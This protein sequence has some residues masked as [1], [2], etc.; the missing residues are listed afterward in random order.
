MPALIISHDSALAF[1][2]RR[3]A[4][5]PPRL[6]SANSAHRA[7]ASTR[8]SMNS[9]LMS[10]VQLLPLFQH[11]PPQ[12]DALVADPLDHRI[13][14]VL[15]LHLQAAPLPNGALV[16]TGVSV[17]Y[18]DGTIQVLVC[19]PE[20]VFVQMAR[21][22]CL[23]E[24]IELGFEL[25]GQFAICPDAPKGMIDRAPVT[26][27]ER[28]RRFVE[29]ASCL[30]GIKLARQAAGHVL[31][32]SKSP[33]ES[34][35]AIFATLQ[36]RNGG[37]QMSAPLLNESL[38]LPANARRVLG[39]ATC[40]PDLYWPR[41]RT[42]LEYDS[43]EHHVGTAAGEHDARKRTVYQMLGLSVY[44][45][46]Y[47]QMSSFATF[48]SIMQ[49]IAAK[50]GRVRPTTPEQDAKRASLHRFLLHGPRRLRFSDSDEVEQ[51]G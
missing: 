35:A 43:D 50:F 45:V 7:L 38:V 40:S 19:S 3:T 48:T 51:K 46:T 24:L 6:L 15:R 29:L 11:L 23:A 32:N 34:Q 20:L 17:P 16:H 2:S 22:M 36:R 25:C 39:A 9:E 13:T 8:A 31:A 5:M 26:T 47:G 28:L 30:R 4:A 44:S 37:L 10:T 12:T 42:V 14:S 1:W 21:F 27:P 49:S 18:G 41:V 33:K